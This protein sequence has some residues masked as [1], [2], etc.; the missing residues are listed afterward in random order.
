MIFMKQRAR[1]EQKSQRLV[2]VACDR[3]SLCPCVQVVDYDDDL[4]LSLDVV[5]ERVLPAEAQLALH[6]EPVLLAEAAVAV[7]DLLALHVH[8]LYPLAI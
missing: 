3:T 7:D 6:H 4:C 8:Q 5:A 1:F 2:S